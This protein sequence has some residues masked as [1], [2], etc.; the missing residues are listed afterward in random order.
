MTSAA[1]TGN[2]NSTT[3]PVIKLIELSVASAD[4]D[5]V[6]FSNS[7]NVDLSAF[8]VSSA[9]AGYWYQALVLDD[10][11]AGTAEATYKLD[12]TGT[13]TMGS[14]HNTSKFGF[15]AFPDSQ[16]AGK[17]V[18]VVNENNTIFRSATSG[19]VRTGVSNPPGAFT[20]GTY[21]QFPN[22]SD[23]KSYWSKLD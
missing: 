20:T 18:F 1:V 4:A 14:C 7:E 13:P 3:D 2:S 17:Y 16:S 10:A 21:S 5:G 8:A 19:A 12:T 11:V 23:L 6:R 15:L 9:K 22:D